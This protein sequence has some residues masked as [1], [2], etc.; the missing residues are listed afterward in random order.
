MTRYIALLFVLTLSACSSV[1]KPDL[2]RLYQRGAEQPWPYP[3]VLIHGV[4]GAK[5]RQRTTGKEVWPGGFW[6]LLLSDYQDLALDMDPHTLKPRASDVEAYAIADEVAGTDFYR[7][8]MTTLQDAGGYLLTHA[9]QPVR[10][11][12]RRYYIF[13]YDWRQDNVLNARRLKQFLDQIRED[14]RTPDLTFD[15][16]AH[17][18]GGLIVRYFQRYGDRDV[19][20]GNNFQPDNAGASYLRRV[21]L[22]GTPNLGSVSALQ[23]ILQGVEVGLNQVDT[24]VLMTMPSAYQLLPHPLNR[25]IVT[26]EGKVLDRDLFDVDLWRRFQW[27]IFD[28]KVRARMRE[29]FDDPEQ[30]EAYIALYERFFERQLERAR[31]FV[32]SLTVP[33]KPGYRSLHV[34]GGDCRA[35]PARILVEDIA[36]ESYVRLKPRSIR[37]PRPDVDYDLL[38]LEPGDG[39]VTKASLLGKSETDPSQPRDAYSFFPLAQDMMFCDEHSRLT[40][41]VTF[42]D[43]LLNLLLRADR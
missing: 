33:L 40:E 3:V 30:A 24:E 13:Y 27:S 29:R 7:N 2:H 26:R 10:D 28:P 36:G 31:R 32:W 41:N 20:D 6:R 8:L 43:N 1:V 18:M 22:V 17:S 38:M 21:I 16:I 15:I 12:H 37:Y 19:L 34:F 35:T 5:L 25:W 4:F 11:W 39:A 14:Y 42:Q 23:N 9:G